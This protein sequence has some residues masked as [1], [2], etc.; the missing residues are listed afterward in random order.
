MLYGELGTTDINSKIMSRMVLFW[1]K[2][3]FQKQDKLS[4][5]LCKF[6]SNLNESSDYNFKWINHIKKTLDNTGFSWVWNSESLNLDYLKSV[7]NQRCTDIFIQNWQADMDQNSQ[8]SSYKLFKD[9][10]QP[11]D[12]FKKLN[13]S[14]AIHLSKF[15]TRTHHLPITKNR[16]DSS[17]STLCTLCD[18]NDIGDEFHYLF[19]C[20]YFSHLRELLLPTN[21]LQIGKEHNY[22]E[23][24]KQDE[25]T[26]KK[27]SK[28]IK[29]I[30]QSFKC[31]VNKNVNKK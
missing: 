3:K 7:F 8:C 23:L 6:L 10:F 28:F 1:G 25:D 11:E 20:N 14:D 16:F 13:T 22:N 15:R 17:Q 30:N 4:A 2:L 31:E 24:F 27:L 21:V 19:S 26:L 18:N 29:A 5:T 12:Y 9:T